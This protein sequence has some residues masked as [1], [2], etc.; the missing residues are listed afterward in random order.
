M[1]DSPTN[2]TTIFQ[3]LW[4]MWR[5]FSNRLS[6]PYRSLHKL[7]KMLLKLGA[8]DKRQEEVS[9]LVEILKFPC[10]SHKGNKSYPAPRS[11]TCYPVMTFS[12]DY[13]HAP[14]LPPSPQVTRKLDRYQSMRRKLRTF[15]L[16]AFLR[17]ESGWISQS[18]RRTKK[19]AFPAPVV[20]VQP[21]PKQCVLKVKDHRIDE[22]SL[23]IILERRNAVTDVSD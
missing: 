11:Y 21:E 4:E 3:D 22:T 12:C 6:G 8:V 5:Y 20:E 13:Y 10:C 17:G 16:P 18:S 23:M 19:K 9:A 1:Q 15:F 7:E 14:P 2:P